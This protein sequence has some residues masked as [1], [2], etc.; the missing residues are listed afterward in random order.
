MAKKYYANTSTGVTVA[1]FLQEWA[2]VQEGER[3]F[4]M[5][6]ELNLSDFSVTLW[7]QPDA[8]TDIM[9]RRWSR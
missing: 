7:E 3:L 4:K 1:E 8:S 5:A 9:V 6:G 2:A